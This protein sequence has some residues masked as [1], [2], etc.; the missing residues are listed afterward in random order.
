MGRASTQAGPKGNRTS[1]QGW[2]KG[3]LPKK[4]AACLAREQAG[5]R[6]EGGRSLLPAL[7]WHGGDAERP[8][9]T[10]ARAGKRT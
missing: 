6:C 3:G 7:G 8:G 4:P 9:E 5:E 2:G 10:P 1:R